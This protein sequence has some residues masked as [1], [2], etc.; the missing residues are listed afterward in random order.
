[1][2]VLECLFMVRFKTAGMMIYICKDMCRAIASKKKKIVQP[3]WKTG[4]KNL[5]LI[6]LFCIVILFVLSGLNI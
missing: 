2:S 4:E 1:M 3:T 6:S 5:I